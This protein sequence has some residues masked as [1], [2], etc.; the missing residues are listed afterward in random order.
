MEVQEL[1]PKSPSLCIN[2][3]VNPLFQSKLLLAQAQSLYL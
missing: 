2:V 3:R 1:C